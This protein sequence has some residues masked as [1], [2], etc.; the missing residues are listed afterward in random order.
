MCTCVC[1]CAMTCVWRGSE[2]ETEPASGQ[3][4][5][6]ATLFDCICCSFSGSWNFLALNGGAP[7]FSPTP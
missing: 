3:E 4:V 7:G 1:A 5:P 2:R 6:M